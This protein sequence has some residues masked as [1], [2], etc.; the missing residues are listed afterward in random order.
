MYPIENVFE[1]HVSTKEDKNTHGR[2]LAM[3]KMLVEDRLNGNISVKNT[4][5]GV[6]FLITLNKEL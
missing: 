3:V 6:E 2:G 5:D 4:H 1:Y